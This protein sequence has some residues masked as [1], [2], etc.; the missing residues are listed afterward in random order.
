MILWINSG[1]SRGFATTNLLDEAGDMIY[2]L[3]SL[4]LPT[5]SVLVFWLFLRRKTT[6]LFVLFQAVWFASLSVWAL[7][8]W[9]YR[10]GMGP[11][12]ISTSGQSALLSFLDGFKVYAVCWAL[13]ELAVILVF[14]R[15]R[16]S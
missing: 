6:R 14:V 5:V 12:A 9:F 13:V 15:R 10:D 8:C 3:M 7:V 2:D 16:S 4:A 1:F 11:D